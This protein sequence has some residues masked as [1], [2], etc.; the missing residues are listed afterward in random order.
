MQFVPK[1]AEELKI[2]RW[3][4]RESIFGAARYDKWTR[5]RWTTPPWGGRT[6]YD[7]RGLGACGYN[8]GDRACK[9]NQKANSWTLY[10][11][12]ESHLPKETREYFHCIERGGRG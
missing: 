9:K 10:T 2:D 6:A 5:D 3:N 1:T 12:A 8:F 7:L 11:E 4:P